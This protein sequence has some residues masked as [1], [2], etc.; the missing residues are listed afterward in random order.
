[1][2]PPL[3]VRFDAGHG[4][5]D[6]G[7]VGPTGLRECDVALQ[8]AGLCASMALADGWTIGFTRS[9]DVFVGLAQRADISNA[10]KDD[11]FVSIH[12][13]GYRR[14]IP[15]GYEVWTT[16]GQTESD[17]VAEHVLQ[18]VGRTFPGTPARLDKS[19]G[20][21]DKEGPLAVLRLTKC[22]AVL[23]EVEFITTPEGEALMRSGEWRARMARAIVD[24]INA[25]RDEQ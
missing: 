3:R 7:A 10:S 11:L 17:R 6:S 9:R 16:K 23:I 25:W 21:G 2:T 8:I 18:R 5:H 22:P 14:P 12:C 13:N 4:G 1:M 20:D 15:L 24:A 19:D